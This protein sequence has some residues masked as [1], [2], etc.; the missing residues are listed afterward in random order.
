MVYSE[1]SPPITL[2]ESVIPISILFDPNQSLYENQRNIA[3]FRASIQGRPFQLS[4]SEETNIQT[5]GVDRPVVNKQFLRD[6]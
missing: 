5:D 3:F 1:A 4:H 2:L 6:N